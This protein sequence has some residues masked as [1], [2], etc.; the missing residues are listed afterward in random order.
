LPESNEIF[1]SR[2]S[3]ERRVVKLA[4]SVVDAISVSIHLV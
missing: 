1:S 3:L 2:V 4:S